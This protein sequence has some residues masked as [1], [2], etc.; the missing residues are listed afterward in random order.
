MT[1]PPY[2]TSQHPPSAL[3]ACHAASHSLEARPASGAAQVTFPWREPKRV[4]DNRAEKSPARGVY[5]ARKLDTIP[6]EGLL[7]E[8]HNADSHK[9]CI[10]KTTH[11]H[12]TILGAPLGSISL[13]LALH[14][15][16]MSPLSSDTSIVSGV[17]TCPAR[18]VGFGYYFPDP[19]KS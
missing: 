17:H 18:K 11:Y 7:L 2:G 4:C 1:S 12:F 19:R 5:M 16:P 14:F 6:A 13:V 15:V 9:S 3:V 10:S 8:P